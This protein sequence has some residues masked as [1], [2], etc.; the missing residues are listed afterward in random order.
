M[1]RDLLRLDLPD[2][3]TPRAVV[4]VLHG[5][6]PRSAQAVDGRSASWRRMAAMQQAVV[7]DLHAVGAA[8]WLLRYSERGWNDGA[9]AADARWALGQ[10]RAA[11][12]DVPVVL[13]GHSMGARTA[14]YVADEAAVRAVVGLAPWWQ[15]D[16]PVHTLVGRSIAAAHGRT[17][18]I[19]SARMTRAYLTRAERVAEETRFVDMGRVGHYMLRRVADWNAAARELT[20]DALT[21]LDGIDAA[22]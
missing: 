14:I 2:G 22:S 4:L 10:V 13:L 17:D 9:P 11:H 19:T 15:P 20:L 3:A 5:G 16:D 18:K 12:G 8:S 6:K 7:A 21:S 1:P